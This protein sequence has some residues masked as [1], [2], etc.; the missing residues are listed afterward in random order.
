MWFGRKDIFLFFVGEIV[1]GKEMDNGWGSNRRNMLHVSKTLLAP[2][3]IIRR[4]STGRFSQSRR[5]IR[6]G[7]ST[8]YRIIFIDTGGGTGGGVVF[9]GLVHAP[10]DRGGP[11]RRPT[12]RDERGGVVIICILISLSIKKYF[13]KKS[14]F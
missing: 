9:L 7:G 6:A 1:R 5:L 4:D 3:R 10:L 13:E 2:A 8:C 11:S 14:Y 12:G